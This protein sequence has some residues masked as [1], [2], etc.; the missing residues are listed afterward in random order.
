VQPL[1]EYEHAKHQDIQFWLTTCKD[2]FDRNPYQW[3]DEADRIKYT[4]SKLRESQLASFA[5]TYW[6][7]MT[8]ELGH[9]RQDGYELWDIFAKQAIGRFGP[10]H[11]E[12]KALREMLKVRYKNDINP[13]V[14]EFESWNVKAK[15]TGIAFR[16]LITDQIPD[17]A[18]RRMSMHQEYA[19]DRVWIEAL[20]QAVR[21]EEDFQEGKR[22]KDNIFSG[23][24]SSGKRNRDEPI[25]T[26]TT[27]KPKYTA[28][29]KWVYQ[30]KK[31]EEKVEK[32]KAA[33][34]QKI[35][36]RVWAN[37]HTGLDQKIVDERKAKGQ[38]TSSTLTNHG[39][40]HCQKE[41]RV[42]T[43]QRKSFKLP[44]GRSNHPKPR[45]PRV[46]AVAEDSGGETSRQASQSPLA[47]TFMEDEEL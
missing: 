11:E 22:L 38:C 12:E 6:N 29:E 32:G 24:N 39:W 45:K 35:M 44:G 46:A 43:I 7:Q 34:R 37:V 26:K 31:K 28:K 41:I 3:Q 36:H 15:V 33:P 19:D 2:F 30:A 42:N 5:M 27:K 8:G 47:W 20:R 13:F 10:T 17:E 14:L 1:L 16:K 4:L 40:K 18:V 21:D 25:V 23:S 9:I